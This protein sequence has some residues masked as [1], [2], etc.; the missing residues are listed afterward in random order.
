MKNPYVLSRPL[1]VFSSWARCRNLHRITPRAQNRE[2]HDLGYTRMPVLCSVLLLLAVAA[3][4]GRDL[5][6]TCRR[7]PYSGRGYADSNWGRMALHAFARVVLLLLQRGVMQTGAD[8]VGTPNKEED[9]WLETRVLEITYTAGGS[10]RDGQQ[11]ATGDCDGDETRPLVYLHSCIS[12]CCTTVVRILR[13][14]G[15]FL[16]LSLLMLL[17]Q[18][19]GCGII[20]SR[21]SMMTIIHDDFCLHWAGLGYTT[22]C[23]CSRPSTNRMPRLARPPLTITSHGLEG[24]TRQRGT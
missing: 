4:G 2:T 13:L 7:L 6:F 21:N 1:Y 3:A 23:C 22:V 10:H 18:Y 12:L 8:M 5:W 16:L 9:P 15:R 19:F 17:L 11:T 24:G 14:A 20:V